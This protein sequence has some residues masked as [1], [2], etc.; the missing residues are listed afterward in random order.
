[1]KISKKAVIESLKE[2]LRN[3]NALCPAFE[4]LVDNYGKLWDI[5][6]KLTRDIKKRGVV[7]KDYSSVGVEIQKNN[8][9]TKELLGVN[10]Q[11]LMILEKLNL[12]TKEIE[13]EDDD[14][15]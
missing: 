3:K 2:Q 15:L 8:P 4:D 1:M 6:E 5:K 9:S 11:M 14:E 7:F 12:S 13:L 10:R